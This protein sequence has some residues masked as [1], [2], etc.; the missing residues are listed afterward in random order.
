[1]V[2]ILTELTSG[3]GDESEPLENLTAC[4]SNFA[5]SDES[6]IKNQR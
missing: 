6:G 5:V 2:L 4:Q 3:W 1:M